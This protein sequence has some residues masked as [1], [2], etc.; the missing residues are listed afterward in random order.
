MDGVMMCGPLPRG[1]CEGEPRWSW[2]NQGRSDAWDGQ[3]ARA[4]EAGVGEEGGWPWGQWVGADS[5]SGTVLR[6]GVGGLNCGS[7]A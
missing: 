6:P 5:V 2:L 3:L 1:C 4:E 7:L